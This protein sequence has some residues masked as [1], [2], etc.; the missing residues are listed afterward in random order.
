V[1]IEPYDAG[2]RSRWNEFVQRSKN[3]TFLFHRSYMEYHADRFEDCSFVVS[4]DVDDGADGRV[5]ALL[6]ACRVGDVLVSHDGLTYGGFVSDSQMTAPL[7][8]RLFE[9]WL[10]HLRREGVHRVVYKCVPHIYHSVPAEEDA[11]ALFRQGARLVRR[12]VSSAID[13]R[14]ALPPGRRRTRALAKAHQAGFRVEESTQFSQFWPL[15]EQNL[16]QRH[17]R[18]PVHTV[19]EMEHLAL[20]FPEN[21]RLFCCLR[22]DETMAGVV[23]YITSNV[24]HVQYNAASAEGRDLS[25]QD[26]VLAA[27]IERYSSTHR[28]VDL[29]ISTERAG[30]HLNEGLIAYKEGFGARSVNYDT[31]ELEL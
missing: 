20:H 9:A 11:Y 5:L 4:G 31:Y 18:R 17:G 13:T 14:S 16:H 26:L 21:I 6:P 23:A 22:D 7:M 19:A 29:G 1:L 28:W 25:A 10:D 3:G 12:D 27:V 2:R 24:C 30:Q 15:L 8:M